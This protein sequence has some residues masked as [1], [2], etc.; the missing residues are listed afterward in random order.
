MGFL[1]QLGGWL[2]GGG[3]GVK[4]VA[5]VADEAFH[6]EQEKAQESAAAIDVDQKDLASARAMQ[7][8]PTPMLTEGGLIAWLVNSFNVL[9]DCSNR[10][11][12][13]GVTLWIIGGFIGW[14]PLPKTDEISEFWQNTFWLVMTF[15]FGGR[16]L[17]KDLPAAVKLMRGL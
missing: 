16:A 11:V 6:T 4:K 7:I 3:D 9:V 1:S 12:R 8:A 2:F 10:L 14:W 17:L 15:W 13:P 5:E